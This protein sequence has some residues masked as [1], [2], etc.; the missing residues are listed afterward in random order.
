M[1]KGGNSLS[2][3]QIGNIT[4]KTEWIAFV[5]ALLLIMLIERFIYK[6]SASMFQDA[7]FYYILVW[8]FSYIFFE[9]PIFIKNPMSVLYFSGGIWGHILGVVVAGGILIY[10]T[11]R[12]NETLIWKDW[13][14]SFAEFYLLFQASVF[15]LSENWTV[16][17]IILVVYILIAIKKSSNESP[18]WMFILIVLNLVFLSYN[19]KVFSIE[20]WTFLVISVIAVSFIVKK[21]K[22]LLKTTISW[23]L[24]VILA[25]SVA[26][27]FEKTNKTVLLEEAPD[28]ELQTLSGETVRLSDYRGKKVILNFWATWCP[29][30]KA[31]MPHMQNFYEEHGDEIEVI[32]VNLTSRDNGMEGVEKFA[33]D[34]GLTFKIPLDVDGVY[35]EQYEI[36]SIPT[37]YVLDEN[38]QIFQKIIGPMDQNTLESYLD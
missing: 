29:P 25:S 17:I 37:T 6:K 20:G 34:Y 7:L 4:V 15:V 12:R 14:Y 35:G 26:L 23:T 30:C 11:K 1:N 18:N 10:K 22:A 8:K 38:G 3:I 21:E 5:I 2:Y 31:E 9:W 36:M 33:R 27:N 24:I 16:G 32:A 19:Q 13:L 28:F